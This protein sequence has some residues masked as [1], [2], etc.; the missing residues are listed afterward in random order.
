MASQFP[1]TA[2]D[3]YTPAA[4]T[5]SLASMMGGTHSASHNAIMDAIIAVQTKLGTDNSADAGSLDYKIRHTEALITAMAHIGTVSNTITTSGINVSLLTNYNLV[6]GVLGLAT[7]LNDA[8]SAQNSLGVA[9]MALATIVL[10]L[11]NK[12]NTLNTALQAQGLES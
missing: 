1:A 4:P 5:D 2:I 11:V 9:Y 3:T 10:D 12:F 6:S 7:G 8:N